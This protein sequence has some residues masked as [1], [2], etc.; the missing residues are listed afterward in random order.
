M[1]VLI[2]HGKESLKKKYVQVLFALSHHGKKRIRE[3]S[4]FGLE[5]IAKKDQVKAILL[6]LFSSN[7][8]VRMSVLNDFIN[9]YNEEE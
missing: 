5:K 8:E 6:Q 9:F 1:K 4:E 7:K 3:L 2:L